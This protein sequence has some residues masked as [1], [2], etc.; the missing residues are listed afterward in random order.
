MRVDVVSTTDI[1]SSESGLVALVVPM[2][3]RPDV[4]SQAGIPESLA[5]ALVK[6][7]ERSGFRG[8][9]GESIQ[10]TQE[11]HGARRFALLGAGDGTEESASRRIGAALV[12]LAREAK[13]ERS[14]IVGVVDAAQARGI[15]EGIMLTGYAFDTYKS[16]S[17]ESGPKARRFAIVADASMHAAVADGVSLASAICDARDL[18]NDHPGSCTPAA[19]A[20]RCSEIAERYGFEITVRDRDALDRDGFRLISAVGR[21]SVESPYLVHMVYK[22]AGKSRRTVAL[23]GK[24]I[25][26]D[27][28]GYSMKPSASQVNM[29][30]DMGGAAAVIGAAEAVGRLRPDGVTVHFVVPAA[31]NLVSNNAYRVMEVVRGY[32]GTT[33]EVLNTDAEGRLIL[34][35]ALAYA[36]EQEVDEIIDVA[37]LTG[38]CVVAL[39]SEVAGVFSNNDALR[40][41][42]VA[43]AKEAD[44]AVWPLPLVTRMEDQ[45]SSDIADVKNV[46]SRWGGA[47]TAA[48]FLQKFVGETPWLHMDIA[49]PGMTDAAWEHIC[50]GGTG[51]GVA[52]LYHHVA[53]AG[54]GIDP[55]IS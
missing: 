52:A 1:P 23:V 2:P 44:E 39:G 31:E 54:A 18:A 40:D 19:L 3:F 12:R 28:G 29:H 38:S 50:K 45:I 15:A 22:P 47:I 41:R 55:T 7:A 25:T 37:T 35:D 46:G 49:G 13:E 34:A 8:K 16:E 30:L 20:T 32:N 9:L 5:T 11:A 27:S 21:G 36:V 10:L 26:Y 4:A 33:V 17:K 42:F 51:F 14:A 53:R 48:L 43:S 6:E 24:G